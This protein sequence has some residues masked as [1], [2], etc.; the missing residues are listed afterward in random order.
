VGLRFLTLH[1]F[2]ESDGVLEDM[3]LKEGRR[4]VDSEGFVGLGEGTLKEFRGR[5]VVELLLPF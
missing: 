2:D 3:L 1:C 5:V 4:D